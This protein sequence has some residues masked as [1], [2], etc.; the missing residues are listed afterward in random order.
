MT[1][2][3]AFLAIHYSISKAPAEGFTYLILEGITVK[4]LNYS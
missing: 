3:W 2:Y 1:D 4:I